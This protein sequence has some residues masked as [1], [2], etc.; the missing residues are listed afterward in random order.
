MVGSPVFRAESIET[1]TL[2]VI[3]ARDNWSFTLP[4]PQMFLARRCEDIT[5]VP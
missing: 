4:T 1:P 2:L 5:S 3:G